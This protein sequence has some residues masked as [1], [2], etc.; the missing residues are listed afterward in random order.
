M[1]VDLHIRRYVKATDNQCTDGVESYL[2]DAYV[3]RRDSNHPNFFVYGTNARTKRPSIEINSNGFDQSAANTEDDDEDDEEPEEELTKNTIWF[4]DEGFE[5]T[6]LV[7]D[8]NGKQVF[9]AVKH[10]QSTTIYQIGVS[11]H[12]SFERDR[13]SVV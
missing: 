5:I 11:R 3:P 7:F 8:E 10:E 2:L 4:V 12:R 1:P 6:A 9:M 13:K